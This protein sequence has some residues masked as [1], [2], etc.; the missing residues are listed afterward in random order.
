MWPLVSTLYAQFRS[1]LAGTD[2]LHE[3]RG[4][5]A[6][7]L[8][9]A[10]WQHQRL[11]RN[12]LKTTDGQPVFI[13]HPGFLNREPGPDFREAVVRIGERPAR[14]GD[15]EV[16]PR[17]GDWLTHKHERNPAYKKVVLHVV[18]RASKDEDSPADLPMLELEPVLDAPLADLSEWLRREPVPECPPFAE[19]KCAAPLRELDPHQLKDLLEQAALFR[20]HARAEQFKARAREAGWTQALW[21]GT[22]RALGYKHNAWPMLRLAELRPHWKQQH[23][24]RTEVLAR[25]LGL[26]GLLPSD[27]GTART[28]SSQYVRRLWDCW[29][30]DRDELAEWILPPEIWRLAGIRP[31]NQPQRRLALAAHWI[32]QGDL[33]DRLQAWCE[34]SCANSR[35]SD[36]L[37][38]V[39]RPK[40]D[41]FWSRHYTLR[42]RPTPKPIPLLGMDR[43]SDLSANVILPWLRARASEGRRREVCLEIERRYRAWPSGADNAVLKLARQRLLDKRKATFPSGLSMQQG[44]LQIVRDYCDH[45]NSLCDQ[46]R[47]PE[48]VRQ[49][50]HPAGCG[51]AGLTCISRHTSEHTTHWSAEL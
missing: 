51:G 40:P 26:S 22:F 35:L 47:F 29:W 44:L 4:L 1:L 36:S 8:L 3:A 50:Q 19:G 12:K 43:V 18:W 7:R 5:P 20:L 24:S 2:T 38:K 45:S 39:L 46:C 25:L 33:S 30:R 48:V 14:T 9:Q 34:S 23:A 37:L 21:E 42:A 13:L 49:I 16:D 31:A 32:V 41:P 15:I 17:P 27:L 10:I 6:E 11:H 28:P